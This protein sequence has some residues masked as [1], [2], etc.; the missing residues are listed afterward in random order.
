MATQRDNITQEV[1]QILKAKGKK[2]TTNPLRD[3][4][5]D[6]RRTSEHLRLS[7]EGLSAF[8]KAKIPM[9]HVD[10]HGTK[11]SKILIKLQRNLSCPYYIRH[12]EI[13]F[14]NSTF[15]ATMLTLMSGNIDQ[16]TNQ[17]E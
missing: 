12:S 4:W 1:V 3:W 8:T 2:I 17:W 10:I 7:L 6:K 5:I 13:I 16:F 11:S 15:D 14:F 9:Y